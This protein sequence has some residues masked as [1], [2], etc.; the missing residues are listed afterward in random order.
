M[1]DLSAYVEGL[2]FLGPGIADWT[3]ARAVLRHEA[4]YRPDKTRYPFVASLPANERRRSSA[5]VR[6]ALSVGLEAAAHAEAAP[7]EM[8]AVFASS[9]GDNYNCHAICEQLA[10]G[11]RL[12]SPTRFHNSVTNAPAGYWSIATGSM[13]SSTT[14]C[15]YDASFGAGLLE[16]LSQVAMDGARCIFIAYDYDYPEPLHGV[17]PIP[18]GLAVALV[19]TPWRTRRSVA[20]LRATLTGDAAHR[21]AEGPLED[22]RLAIPAARALPLLRLIADE[23]AGH[24]VLDYLDSA[25]IAVEIT[26]CT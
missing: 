2:G 23:G 22:M 17:R 24:V 4:A 12:L 21:L 19:L 6:L 5:V 25:R 20:A 18:D 9:G 8:P 13:A 7:K 3:E 14:I 10:T 16:A 26:P 1:C 11:D 15:A